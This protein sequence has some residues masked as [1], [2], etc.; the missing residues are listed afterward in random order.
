MENTRNGELGKLTENLS[1]VRAMNAEELGFPEDTVL[2]DNIRMESINKQLRKMQNHYSP[3]KKLQLLL[4]ALALAVPHLPLLSSSELQR[5]QQQQSFVATQPSNSSVFLSPIAQTSNS[6]GAGCGRLRTNSG[7]SSSGAMAAALKHPP[8]DA[9]AVPHLPL[10]SSSE[11]QRQQ[12][13]QSFVATQ[14]SNS[15]VFLSPIA[16]TS[17]SIGAGCG[18]LRTN[19]GSSSSGAM[20]A[21]LK[22]P[23]ADELIRWLVYLLARSSTINCEIEA[24][25]MWELL[26]QQVLSTGDASYFLSILFSAVHVIKHPGFFNYKFLQFKLIFFCSH[27][28]T[29]I[30]KNFRSC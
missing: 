25:Y 10:L 26:P 6:I 30:Y 7:S 13:Q 4:R 18:R 23:P 5:Q 9:L 15:S 24:W 12:Q 8:A 22:H 19:S 16:Q 27:D 11:L 17:N 28:H 29:P 1:L 3:L 2:P 21:A 20:A 14:P